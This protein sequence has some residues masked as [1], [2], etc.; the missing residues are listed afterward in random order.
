MNVGK[1]IDMTIKKKKISYDELAMITGLSYSYIAN[2][3]IKKNMQA[4][5]IVFFANAINVNAVTL[6]KLALE[7]DD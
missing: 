5:T 2:I 1:A 7:I 3:K 6:F 4:A